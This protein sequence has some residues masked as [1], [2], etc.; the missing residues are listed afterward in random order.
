VS[1]YQPDDERPATGPYLCCRCCGTNDLDNG[2]VTYWV[3]SCPTKDRHPHPCI[4]CG[5]RTK[6]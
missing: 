1:R 4:M 2:A 3:A 5:Q 6:E